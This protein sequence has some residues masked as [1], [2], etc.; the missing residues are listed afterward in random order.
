M[1]L[2][3]IMVI[4]LASGFH[5]STFSNVFIVVPFR[6]TVYI[7]CTIYSSTKKQYR[8][9]RVLELCVTSKFYFF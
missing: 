4:P 5:Y 2:L 7:V 9:N 6:W 3:L 1:V 8:F